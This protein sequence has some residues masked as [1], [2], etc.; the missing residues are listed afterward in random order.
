MQSYC[1]ASVFEGERGGVAYIME[2]APVDCQEDDNYAGD[3][4]IRVVSY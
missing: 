1:N 2:A 3:Y 4:L